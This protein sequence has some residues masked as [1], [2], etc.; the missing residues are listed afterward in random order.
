MELAAIM[1]AINT[2]AAVAQSLMAIGQNAAPIIAKIV[3]FTAKGENV[4][5]ADVDALRATAKELSAQIMKPLPEE[6]D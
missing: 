4:T 5:Q 6:L 2:A 3:G 1:G